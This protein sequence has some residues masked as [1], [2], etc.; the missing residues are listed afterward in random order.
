MDEPGLW[1]VL[2]GAIVRPVRVISAKR[3]DFCG[4]FDEF[5]ADSGFF[6]GAG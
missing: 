2:G 6:A 5:I 1:H 4:S 3:G